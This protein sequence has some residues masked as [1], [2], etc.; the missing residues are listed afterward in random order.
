M[1]KSVLIL[2]AALAVAQPALAHH[3][4]DYESRMRAAANLPESWFACK[5]KDDCT[6]VAVPCQSDLAVASGHRDDARVALIR[7]FPFCLG[8]DLH[9]TAAACRKR[10]CVTEPATQ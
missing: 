7:A 3:L 5:S 8:S 4:D 1:K 2:T 10:R 6:L 9:D